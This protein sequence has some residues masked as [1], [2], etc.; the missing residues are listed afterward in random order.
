[1]TK[2]NVRT[3]VYTVKKVA[4]FPSPSWMSLTPNSPWP[5]II[6]MIPG[7]GEFGKDIPAGD[8]KTANPFLQCMRFV[9]A[10]YSKVKLTT[11]SGLSLSM[12]SYFFHQELI[13]SFLKASRKLFL[14]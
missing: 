11:T 8:G 10:T 7:E 6:K 12:S 2:A 13:S 1:M 14:G 9:E 4:V 5:G 3:W